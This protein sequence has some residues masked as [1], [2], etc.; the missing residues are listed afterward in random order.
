MSFSNPLIIDFDFN[1]IFPTSIEN[2]NVIE[3]KIGRNYETDTFFTACIKINSEFNIWGDS[4]HSICVVLSNYLDSIKEKETRDIKPYCKYFN[5]VLKSELKN[6]KTSCNGEKLCYQKMMEIY[7]HYKKVD[8][9]KCKDDIIDLTDDIF[10]ILNYLNSLYNY[11]KKLKNNSSICNFGSSCFNN[12]KD[13]L[14]KC[15]S[16]QNNSLQELQKIVEKEYKPYIHMNHDVLDASKHMHSSPYASEHAHSFYS[17]SARKYTPSR[18]Y[19]QQRIRKLKELWNKKRKKKFTLISSFD[20][21]YEEYID[22]GLD[23]SYNV[24]E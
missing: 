5:Y 13:F 2:F 12:Y 19:L 6:Y 20:C 16:I 1:G 17:I 24:L 23:I 4:F 9:D 8:M 21:K 14:H 15:K 3:D 22:K 7:K 18:L 10:T 11:L